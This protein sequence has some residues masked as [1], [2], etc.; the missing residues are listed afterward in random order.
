MNDDD[1]EQLKLFLERLET[2]VQKILATRG[3]T[4]DVKHLKILHE[5][6]REQLTDEN[7]RSAAR[8]IR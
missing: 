7:T 8:P 2:S 6:I 4:G 5:M 3:Y 1:K